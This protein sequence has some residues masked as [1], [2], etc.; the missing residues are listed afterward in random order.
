MNGGYLWL[1][2]ITLA[3][4]P[5]SVAASRGFVREHLLS[6]DLPLLVDDV[7]LVASELATN[8]LLH[9]ATPFTVTITAYPDNVV[10]TVKDGSPRNLIRVDAQTDDPSGRG[11]AIVDLVS[12]DWGV[13]VDA[14]GGKSVW[15]AFDAHTR[16]LG[17][18]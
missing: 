17:S 5:E 1:H 12:R 7:T 11:I 3:P 4:Q 14:S 6:H 9:A 13:A 2:E 18:P 15:A 16:R 10:L 8:A